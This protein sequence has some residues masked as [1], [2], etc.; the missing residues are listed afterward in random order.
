MATNSG[1]IDLRLCG[2]F[3]GMCLLVL[4][5]SFVA[6]GY[7][8]RL[9]APDLTAGSG[10][11]GNAYSLSGTVVNSVTGEPIHR[12]AV[13]MFEIGS[14]G[15]R[16]TLTD[17][18]G[19]FEFDGLAEGQAVVGA[20]KPGFLD[21]QGNRRKLVQIG[22]DVPS[23][24]LKM[25]P[26]GVIV[27]RV[28]TRD[29]QPLE[30]FHLHVMSKQTANGGST[31]VDLGSQAQTDEDGNFRIAGLPGGSYYVIVDQN[32]QT[33]LSEPG[34]ANA[35]E[36]GY[37]TIFYPGVSEIS[38]AT[39][40]ELSAGGE[41]EANF[42]LAAEPFYRVSGRASS[43]ENLTQ[44]VF[45]RKAGEG[46]DFAQ[47]VPAQDGKFQTKLPAGSYAVMGL[48][49]QGMQLSTS[50]ASLV[51]GSDS[52]DIH[53][54]LKLPVSIQVE[55]RTEQSGDT[56]NRILPQPGGTPPI[57]MQLMS[58]A[59]LHPA[60]YWWGSPSTGI[61]NVKPGVYSAHINTAGQ[62]WV[63]SAQ[64]G[65]VNLLSD[66]LALADGAQPPPIELTLRDDGATITGT[67]SPVEEAELATVLLVQV[68]RR[69]NL[70]N[71]VDSVQGTFQFQG[72]A[73]GDYALLALD[74]ADQLEYSNPE[75]LNPYLSNAV[76]IS[77]QP[78][79]TAN[80]NLS[81]SPEGR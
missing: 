57:N 53:L 68:R 54:A 62:L 67:V 50:G 42:T 40:L 18:A 77:V 15:S 39:A 30:D 20:T 6:A 24:L 7:A 14:Q 61:Q 36:R 81:L 55:V 35:R 75:I 52:L 2:G 41:M 78:H 71:V 22:H 25:A 60:V 13:D 58:T 43:H 38:A 19:H 11:G 45:T 72:V 1:N 16:V 79:G 66:D 27:G 48:T 44:L 23:V 76:H 26:A 69:R 9:G 59:P 70:I 12:A 51:I 28:T 80:V 5:C 74:S 31:W 65:N 4:V 47:T 63:K 17:S 73:P 10:A 32:Q 46:E 3:T 56:P 49:D 64:C 34:I 29:E 21:A 33:T 37:P 8:Q